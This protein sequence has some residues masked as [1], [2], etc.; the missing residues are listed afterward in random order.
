MKKITLLAVAFYSSLASFAQEDKKDET[1][2]RKSNWILEASVGNIK[3]V[4]PY[5]ETYYSSKPN[6]FFGQWEP[7]S[8]SLGGRYLVG[9]I[10]SVKVS[11]GYDRFR[12]Y[13]SVSQSTGAEAKPFEMRQINVQFQGVA[14]GAKLFNVTK[15]LGRFGFLF[16]GGVQVVSMTSKTENIWIPGGDLEN[17]NYNQT[18]YNGGLIFGVTPQFRMTKKLAI[19]LDVT[20]VHNYRQHFNWDGSYSD[21]RENLSGSTVSLNLG[22]SFS[23][24]RGNI[25]GDWFITPNGDNEKLKILEK[26]VGDL[27]NLMSDMDKDGVPDYL[28]QENNSVAGVAVDSRGKMLDINRNGVPDELERGKDGMNG[29]NS[30]IISKDDA[31]KLFIEK[32]YINVFYDLGKDV[33]NSGSTNNVFYIVKF[34][35]NYPDSKITLMGFADERGSSEINDALSSRRA[36]NLADIIKASGIDINRVKI[37]GK[38]ESTEF[39]STELG[40]DLSRRVSVKLE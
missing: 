36:K 40:Y 22:L 3:G 2:G 12:N 9:E 21:D 23:L 1:G 27:E 26:R 15:E 31:I 4:K 17:H 38:G 7:N 19:Q 29:I 24:D 16:H 11:A 25:H 6:G 30:A 5:A 13:N 33:P 8:F 28:D 20:S 32:G 14:N 35:K 10:F 34:L 37:V 39:L 18:E